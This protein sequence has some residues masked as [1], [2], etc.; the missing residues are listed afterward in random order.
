LRAI[1]ST[2]NG[3][4]FIRIILQLRDEFI[5]FDVR[6]GSSGS[7]DNAV[8][9]LSQY[10]LARNDASFSKRLLDR[11]RVGEDFQ[12]NERQKI[13]E[14]IETKCT[15]TPG[16][17]KAAALWK[18][19]GEAALIIKNAEEQYATMRTEINEWEKEKE[20]IAK[21]Q[22][23]ESEIKLDV[24]GSRFTTS[25]TTLRRF[26]DSMIGAM[27]SGRHSLDL[28][29]DGYF[30]IDRDGTHFRYILNFLRSPE[31]F[32]LP[33]ADELK[34]ELLSEA[35]YYGLDQ[36]MFPFTK[37]ADVSI[38]TFSGGYTLILSQDDHGL[39][40]G[41][42]SQHGMAKPSLVAVCGKC[43]SGTFGDPLSGYGSLFFPSGTFNPTIRA[44]TAAQPDA[45]HLCRSCGPY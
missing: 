41:F 6:N 32:K 2:F 36:V 11:I 33:S 40:Y 30:F 7:F 10:I 35:H 19:E 39:W 42:S 24:G 5:S 14:D 23:F 26:P 43:Y 9:E 21:I 20:K 45:H 25:L 4:S 34:D 27:F 16:D 15:T 8:W 12:I 38:Q 1:C 22:Q 3:V 28:N 44:L 17:M 31:T 18:A 29:K 13:A 37:A